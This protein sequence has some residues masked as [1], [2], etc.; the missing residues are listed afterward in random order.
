MS[1]QEEEDLATMVHA[2]PYPFVSQP[3]CLF[4]L[5]RLVP[6]RELVQVQGDPLWSRRL[7]QGLGE[8][9]PLSLLKPP[10]PLL[11]DTDHLFS[12]LLHWQGEEARIGL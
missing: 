10:D 8:M 11:L 6:A 7:M 1:L 3:P 12:K 5:L 4:L 2:R 9:I